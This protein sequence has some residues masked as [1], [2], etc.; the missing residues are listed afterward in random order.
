MSTSDAI[1]DEAIVLHEQGKTDEAM[2]KLK[3]LIA[4]E[5]EYALAHSAL[6]VYLGRQERYDD[7]IEHARIVCDLES[8][9]PFSFV[10]L[11]LVCQKAGRIAE[12]EQA[13]MQARQAQ[14]LAKLNRANA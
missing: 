5:P 1:Y 11:S 14:A 10:A 12:A 7:A 9:D 2:A 8:D 4:Q 3:E 6:S 13:L